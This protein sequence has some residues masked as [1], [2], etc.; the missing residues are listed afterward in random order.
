M[1]SGLT[2]SPKNYCKLEIFGVN[3]LPLHALSHNQTCKAQ[4][5]C[6]RAHHINQVPYTNSIHNTDLKF[7]IF[8][9]L[10]RPEYMFQGD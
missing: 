5:H 6:K 9:K 2:K 1:D 3:F 7:T 4:I 10:Q 8:C